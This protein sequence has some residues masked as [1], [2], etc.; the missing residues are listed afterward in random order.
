MFSNPLP[1]PK[2]KT[3]QKTKKLGG[4]REFSSQIL[5]NVII[6][7]QYGP[8]YISQAP[9]LNRPP[10]QFLKL[11]CM[12]TLLMLPVV[13]MHA[14]RSLDPSTWPCIH[15]GNQS[16]PEQEM[17]RGHTRPETLSVTRHL[18]CLH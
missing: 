8:V 7:E 4:K 3:K 15:S 6:V 16:S 12:N 17:C 13:H 2:T 9:I 18:F 10:A 5:L 11:V 14:I 1:P